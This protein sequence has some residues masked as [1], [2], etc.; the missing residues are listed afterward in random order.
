[1]LI[2]YPTS[3]RPLRASWVAQGISLGARL[4]ILDSDEDADLLHAYAGDWYFYR[5]AGA[6]FDWGFHGDL[7]KVLHDFAASAPHSILRGYRYPTLAELA[8][9]AERRVFDTLTTTG[10]ARPVDHIE[11]LASP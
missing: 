11:G 2:P 5:P 3:H 10:N 1:M 7:E 6:D 4:A 9:L 8:E